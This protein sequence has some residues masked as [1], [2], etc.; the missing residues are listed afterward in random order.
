MKSFLLLIIITILTACASS[1]TA[2]EDQQKQKAPAHHKK[3]ICNEVCRGVDILLYDDPS[4]HGSTATCSY[5]DERLLIK[6]K[7]KLSQARMRRFVFLSFV[8]VGLK[9]NNDFMLPPQIYVGY[10][11]ACQNLS[12]S[13]AMHLQEAAKYSGDFGMMIS[14]NAANQAPTVK[15]PK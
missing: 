7:Y 5:T 8:A 4:G 3:W 12:R 15:C 1:S 14:I 13:D 10:G 6:P 9:G 11:D 2:Q